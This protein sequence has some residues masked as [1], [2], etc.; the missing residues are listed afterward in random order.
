MPKRKR[1]DVD[2]LKKVFRIRNGNLERLNY[3]YPNGKWAVVENKKNH[4]TGYC[5]VGFN[6]GMI[7]YH[8]IIWIL[9]TSKDIP[10]GLEIDHIN[11]NTIDNRIEN[12]TFD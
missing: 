10:Q 2:E 9:S 7:S 5:H 4:S 8:V 6:G 1:I 3:R 12:L 11:G